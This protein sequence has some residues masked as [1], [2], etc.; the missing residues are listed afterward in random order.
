MAPQPSGVELQPRTPVDVAGEQSHPDVVVLGQ[1]RKEMPDTRQHLDRIVRQA[2]LEVSEIS[3]PETLQPLI[4]LRS[5]EPG[6]DEQLA[7]DLW[8]GLPGEADHLHGSGR[9]IRLDE[10]IHESVLGRTAP[11]EGAVDV[12]EDEPSHSIVDESV[13]EAG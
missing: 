12:E 10:G 5:L 1:D 4:D 2:L 9:A 7:R 11:D 3:L 13:R 8:I 6:S